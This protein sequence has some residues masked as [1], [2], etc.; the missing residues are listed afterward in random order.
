[1][2]TSGRHVE[3]IEKMIE[4]T[5]CESREITHNCEVMKFIADAEHGRIGTLTFKGWTFQSF[6]SHRIQAQQDNKP[7]VTF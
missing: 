4:L 3:I 6:P 2:K 1:M 5:G 7:A